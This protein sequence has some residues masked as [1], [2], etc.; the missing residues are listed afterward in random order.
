M[1]IQLLIWLA[2]FRVQRTKWFC[3]ETNQTVGLKVVYKQLKCHESFT[4]LPN[5]PPRPLNAMIA[6]E[7]FLEACMLSSLAYET[8]MKKNS[9]ASLPDCFTASFQYL[10]S[11][12]VKDHW[13]PHKV[14]CPVHARARF[15]TIY[16][17]FTNESVFC[18]LVLQEHHPVQLECV[19]WLPH[20][21]YTLCVLV[22]GKGNLD[23]HYTWS[24]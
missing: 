24:F 9:L 11:A 17:Q 1:V 14:N 5:T 10:L 12:N 2:H 13:P 6:G 15:L 23:M 8:N 22:L 21:C 19:L 18:A 20:R 3:L 16:E 4:S 7:Q